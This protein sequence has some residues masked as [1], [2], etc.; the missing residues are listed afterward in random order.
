PVASNACTSTAAGV[1]I[2][3]GVLTATDPE[4]QALTF[5][6][7]TNGTKGSA[8]VF[9]NG[10][11]TYTPYTNLPSGDGQARGQDKFTYRVTDSGGLSA[12]GTVWV[13][14]DG[15]VRIMPLGDSITAGITTGSLP[16]T[17]NRIGYRKD[18]YNGLTTLSAGK[19]GIDLVGSQS[20]GSNYTFDLNH[21][22]HPGWCDDLATACT[23][24][25]GIAENVISFLNANPADVI[26]LH[27][28]T[29]YFNTSNA[30]VNSILNNIN[31]W[32]QSNYPITVMVARIIPA[33]DGSL[34][35]QTFNNN[36][37][38]IATDRPY[39]KVFRVD[40]Q[41]ELHLT[42]DPT[43]NYADP[44]LMTTGNNLH[45]NAAGY[46]KMANRWQ[47]DLITDNVL[48]GCP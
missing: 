40:E 19:Y 41:G 45:P 8:T 34:N 9:A 15:K 46:T 32:A 1:G 7:F 20:D 21:E 36:V 10:T 42:G 11:F 23:G 6:L 47:A 48:P 30:G 33:V 29:N 43:G 28:G 26:L 17:G 39:V 25:N 44:S 5:E 24:F 13:L 4:N 2:G 35:V 14:L 12:T 37:A 3:N 27:I 38:A 31:T 18:L 16:A 22:G